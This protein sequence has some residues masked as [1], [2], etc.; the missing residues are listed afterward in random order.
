MDA[1][2]RLLAGILDEAAASRAADFG[3][4]DAGGARAT[5]GRRGGQRRHRKQE[6][7]AGAVHRIRTLPCC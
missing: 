7:N 6:T 5:V 3:L 4:F 2:C 1:F